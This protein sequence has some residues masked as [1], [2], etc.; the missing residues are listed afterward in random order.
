MNVD[1]LQRIARLLPVFVTVAETEQ[2]TVA[3]AILRMPQPT[4]SRAVAALGRLLG[5]PV[6]ERAG[7]GIVLTAAGRALLPYARAALDQLVAGVAAAG[8]SEAV[9]RGEVAIAFQNMLGEAVVPA[10]IKRFL[11]RFPAADFALTQGSRQ[12]CLSALDH[13]DSAVALVAAPSGRAD[14]VTIDLYTEPVFLVV[15]RRHRLAERDRVSLTA[16]LGEELIVLKRGYGLRLMIEELFATLSAE[17]RIAFEAED[18]H[19]AR[20]LVS[21][22]LGVSI[23]PSFPADPEVVQVRID[24]SRAIRT[25]G[26]LARPGSTTPS[27]A[28]FIDFLRTSGAAVA[29]GAVGSYARP[30]GSDLNDRHPALGLTQ[31]KA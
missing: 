28:A 2:V 10:L 25:I 7:R 1:E 9:G 31:L 19:T 5:T 26:A 21:A 16:I 4:V 27:V 12:H 13:G 15:P 20:G 30:L 17:P 24:H 23:L 11:E 6:V 29:A 18:A 3:A 8:A 22:G 14:L